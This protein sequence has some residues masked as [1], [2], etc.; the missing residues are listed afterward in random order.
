[1]ET[2]RKLQTVIDRIKRR[3]ALSRKNYLQ[4]MEQAGKAASVPAEIP[5]SNLAHSL[6]SLDEHDKQ[7]FLQQP[8]ARIGIVSSYNDLLS[9]HQPFH[10]FPMIIKKALAQEGLA[11]QFAGGV[12]AMC[13]GITQGRNG[14]ELSLFSRDTIAMS[15]A[16]A[17]SHDVFQGVIAL[18]T[19]DKIV[20][21]LIMGLLSFAYMPVIF[22][23]AGPMPSGLGH[24]E[25]QNL[26]ERFAVGQASRS[27]LLA[28]EMQ[29][30]HAPGTCTFYGTANTNQLLMEF[31]GLHLPGSTLFQANAAIRDPLTIFGA[32]HLGRVVKAADPDKALMRILTEE[33]FVNAIVALMASGGSTNHTLH[34]PAMAKCA[35]IQL[36]WQ[37]FD[38]ISRMTPQLVRIYPNGQADVN[39]FH[40]A[41]GSGFLL[42]ELLSLGLLTEKVQTIWG[43]GLASYTQCPDLEG[44]QLRWQE[45]PNQSAN[46]DVLR[47]SHSPFVADGGLRLVEGDQLGRAIV[48]VSALKPEQRRI[49][50][51]ALV[52]HDW[53]EVEAAFNQGA[54]DRDAVIVLPFQGPCANGMPELHKISSL[55]GIVQDRGYRVALLT[56]GRLSG[57]SAKVLA[58]VHL[59]PEAFRGGG[60]GRLRTGDMVSIDAENGLL[61]VQA[62]DWMSRE[63]SRANQKAPV[64][65][66]REWFYWMRQSVSQADQGATV[67]SGAPDREI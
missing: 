13:D 25:K 62:D 48:K 20:P 19:C 5:C 30:Y 42:R 22:L 45:A 40:A 7:K 27:E 57:A 3:S 4:S 29:T 49:T 46:L 1:M 9:A 32:Q 18:G 2:N 56:D 38:E 21:G 14:M 37:D 16:V 15:T 8:L 66:G 60:I 67:Y 47:P 65:S 55:L 28:G 34:L 10:R 26:R 61:A 24:R 53:Q 58:A 63:K 39:D 31:L 50:A 44:D 52:Y 36:D 35:G 23:P 59:S 54:L 51:P 12:P 33:S 43:Q 64:G 6:A 17:L 41:G 11:C